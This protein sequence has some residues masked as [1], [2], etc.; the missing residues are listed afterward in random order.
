MG[1]NV[2]IDE[3]AIRPIVAQAVM[4][5]IGE[6]RRDRLIADAL[7][8]LLAPKVVKDPYHRDRRE[9]SPLEEA[10]QHAVAASARTVVNQL[11]AEPKYQRAVEK[12]VRDGMDQAL[13]EREGESG[14]LFDAIGNAVRDKVV[15]MMRGED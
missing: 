13:R 10:L 2:S 5:Q 3:E 1:T 12:A 4:E 9:P 15:S 14:W 7:E 6:E 8:Y 11:L